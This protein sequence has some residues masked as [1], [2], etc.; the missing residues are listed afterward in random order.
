[1][2]G[3]RSHT[4][5]SIIT[6]C[7]GDEAGIGGGVKSG[8]TGSICRPKT[9]SESVRIEGNYAVR[10]N[11]IWYM[12]NGNTE[13][14][15]AY[16]KSTE[17]YDSTPPVA[18]LDTPRY[19]QVAQAAIP[20][21]GPVPMPVPPV[22]MPGTQENQEFSSN[23]NKLFEPDPVERMLRSREARN[24]NT[25]VNALAN[26]EIT[27]PGFEPG[28]VFSSNKGNAEKLVEHIAGQKLELRELGDDEIEAMLQPYRVKNPAAQTTGPDEDPNEPEREPQKLAPAPLITA[29]NV[30]ITS[31]CKELHRCFYPYGDGLDKD[32]FKRQLHLQERGLNKLSPPEYA[33]NRARFIADPVGMRARSKPLQDKTRRD[34]RTKKRPE[35][36]DLY[37]DNWKSELDKH[38]KTQAALHAP[39][40]IAGGSYDSVADPSI[41][42]E[43]R[44]GGLRENSSLG[45]QWTSRVHAVDKHVAEQIKNNC[46]HIQVRLEMCYGTATGEKRYM[47]DVQE[48]G[49]FGRPKH[50]PQ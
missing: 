18:K 15:L 13:G 49:T 41:A 34:Y 9:W 40:M 45:R 26:G 24:V 1:M 25:I 16:I 29:G 5:A 4:S 6:Q 38:M 47:P 22:A 39:D 48:D 43:D 46:L 21:P 14:K 35:Y 50:L 3:K 42:I 27:V 17:V 44:V 33:A 32:E 20:M 23:F 8:T 12:N 10:H 31:R 7:H 19:Q 37:A 28:G 2:T 11:D 30:R 36:E